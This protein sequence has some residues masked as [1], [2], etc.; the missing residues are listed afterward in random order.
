MALVSLE[1]LGDPGGDKTYAA[2]HLDTNTL[3]P[4][5]AAPARGDATS[6]DGTR[7]LAVGDGKVTV[8]PKG[9]A[10]RTLVLD[11]RDARAAEPDCCKW[12]DNRYVSFPAKTLGV[13]DTDTMK[14]AFAPPSGDDDEQRII[15]LAGSLQALVTN[16]DDLVLAKI[17]P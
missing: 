12:L 3:E 9:G 13:I 10:A 15:P 6:P 8:T 2:W 4:L 11:P 17:V 1:D 14:I 16:G 5:A 7:T